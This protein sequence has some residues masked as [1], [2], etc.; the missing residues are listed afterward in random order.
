MGTV[1]IAVVVF[2]IPLVVL[3]LLFK[4]VRKLMPPQRLEVPFREFRDEEPPDDGDVT[5]DREPRRPL[6]P[7]G[8]V[9]VALALQM[10]EPSDVQ[11][12]I[13]L[14]DQSRGGSNPGHRLAG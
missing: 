13:P 8:S 9:A 11:A 2:A 3:L 14:R 5:G 6:T 10:R 1:A 7:T 4:T 12:P